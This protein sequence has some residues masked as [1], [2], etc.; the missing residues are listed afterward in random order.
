MRNLNYDGNSDSSGRSQSNSND[1]TKTPFERKKEK[2]LYKGETSKQRSYINS[3]R[4]VSFT[5]PKNKIYFFDPRRVPLKSIRIRS[6]VENTQKVC[7]RSLDN[8][9]KKGKQIYRV[10]NPQK[11][12]GPAKKPRKGPWK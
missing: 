4:K 7:P 9:K 2:K 10:K 12:M 6:S 1:K 3:K 11:P 8:L 5:S